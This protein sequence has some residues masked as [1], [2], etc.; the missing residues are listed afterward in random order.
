MSLLTTLCNFYNI[1]WESWDD[2]F[3]ST[4]P[5]SMEDAVQAYSG[6][7]QRDLADKMG[8]DID[9]LDLMRTRLEEF[10][11]E[12]TSALSGKRTRKHR[13]SNEGRDVK[14]E[15]PDPPQPVEGSSTQ[16]QIGERPRPPLTAPRVPIED[17]L[18]D[19]PSQQS[20]SSKGTHLGWET[21]SAKVDASRKKLVQDHERRNT[22]LNTLPL[23]LSNE[24]GRASQSPKSGSTELL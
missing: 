22:N 21:Q 2:S 24:T 17:L 13:S 7:A 16:P 8:L 19:T 6:L 10:R 9:Q 18:R 11:M 4:S 5:Q 1:D 20:P 14:R 12:T 15:R 23:R 3:D